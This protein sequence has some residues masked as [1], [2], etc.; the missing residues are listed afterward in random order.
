MFSFELCIYRWLH[1]KRVWKLCR[2]ARWDMQFDRG[3]ARVPNHICPFECHPIRPP[4]VRL[5]CAFLTC[6]AGSDARCR[7]RKCRWPHPTRFSPDAQST[8]WWKFLRDCRARTNIRSAVLACN[9]SRAC[10][11]V[12]CWSDH[13]RI[14]LKSICWR[15]LW[16]CQRRIPKRILFESDRRT[17]FAVPMIRCRLP[18]ATVWSARRNSRARHRS[19]AL[20]RTDRQ[21]SRATVD[22]KAP[23]APNGANGDEN[24]PIGL[25]ETI[26][27]DFC[28]CLSSTK[29]RWF[30]T[31]SQLMLS[32]SLFRCFFCFLFFFVSPK[33]PTLS[34]C[35][36]W[37]CLSTCVC[38]SSGYVMLVVI[39]QP[40]QWKVYES[41]S[42]NKLRWRRRERRQRRGKQSSGGGR[43]RRKCEQIDLMAKQFWAIN[44]W[45]I[46]TRKSSEEEPGEKEAAAVR[47]QEEMSA[48]DAAVKEKKVSTGTKINESKWIGRWSRQA[49]IAGQCKKKKLI[50]IDLEWVWRVCRSG[51]A[52]NLFRQMKKKRERKKERTASCRWRSRRVCG[53]VRL[54]LSAGAARILSSTST[55]DTFLVA[56]TNA[57]RE[58]AIKRF[59]KMSACPVPIITSVERKASQRWPTRPRFHVPI[60]HAPIS[61]DFGNFDRIK[62]DVVIW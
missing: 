46:E 45:W 28:C 49:L 43:R 5:G 35:I 62:N 59:I 2:A 36:D 21:T 52:L 25:T 60:T 16:H 18:T 10:F 27:R 41:H 29:N 40:N 47:E 7:R 4:P 57:H 61:D 50:G 38:S 6:S 37:S 20:R 55:T 1:S 44:K 23:A 33:L 3:P 51:V 31:D 9:R 30:Q 15:P 54:V 56:V 22:E 58:S 13:R 24:F 8:L 42:V 34:V 48:K 11:S 12:L 14:S 39:G 19:R 26:D 53:W 17:M 32:F